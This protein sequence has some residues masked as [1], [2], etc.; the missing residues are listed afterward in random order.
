MSKIVF[1]NHYHRGDLHTH[2]GFIAQI[3]NELPD[4]NLEY[5]HRNPSRLTEEYGIP[6]MGLPEHLDHRTPFYQD[7]ENGTL[8]IN[9]WAGTDLDR[10]CKYRGVNMDLLIDQ[11]TGIFETINKFFSVDIK[12][13]EAKESYLPVLNLDFVE[14]EN[15]DAYIGSAQRKRVLIC[16]NVPFSSQSFADDMSKFLIPIAE[17]NLDVDVICTNKFETTLSNI[18]FTS[19]IIKST[20]DTDL[21]EISYLSNFC[22][23]IVGKNSGPYV[24]CET[25]ANY[26][27]PNKTIVSFNK[28]DP[29]HGPDLNT[30]SCENVSCKYTTIP[31]ENISNLTETDINSIVSVLESVIPNEKT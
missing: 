9:T 7:V 15:V 29:V 19:D 5:L 1:F 13:R 4:I 31:I 30:M 11:W 25:Y 22:D 24:F 20:K 10:L 17:N 3:Q 8:F 27:N 18:K 6:L 21:L 16:N 28:G 26:N 2:K 12:I 14:K 23:V